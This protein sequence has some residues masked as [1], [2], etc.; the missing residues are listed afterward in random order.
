VLGVGL[1]EFEWLQTE[2]ERPSLN[3]TFVDLRCTILSHPYNHYF[4]RVA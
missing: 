4:T 1:I 3:C 2:L